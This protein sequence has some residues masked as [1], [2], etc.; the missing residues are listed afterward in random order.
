MDGPFQTRRSRKRLGINITPLVDVMFIL[1]IFFTVSSTFRSHLGV[2]VVLPRS[3]TAMEEAQGTHELAVNAAGDFYWNGRRVDAAALDAELNA[4]L[5][6]DPEA[7]I[8]LRG[9]EAAPFQAVVAAMDAARQAGAV[10]LVIPTQIKE[11]AG[12]P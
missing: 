5:Q 4:L 2:D 12:T 6:R 9:D 10:H 8:V 11:A 3:S 1:I 7:A